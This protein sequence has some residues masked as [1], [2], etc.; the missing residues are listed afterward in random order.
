MRCL[1]FSSGDDAGKN[2][3]ATAGAGAAEAAALAS[4][5]VWVLSASFPLAFLPKSMALFPES[6]LN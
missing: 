3:G 6:L 5:A 4:T 2:D 1:A